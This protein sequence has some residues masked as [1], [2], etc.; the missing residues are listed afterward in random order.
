MEQHLRFLERQVASPDLKWEVLV[1]DNNCK[2]STPEMLRQAAL[3]FPVP[4]RFVREEKQG[5]SHARNR[6]IR[7]SRGKYL[8]FTDD[9]TQPDHAWVESV[10]RTFKERKCDAVAG[11]IALKLAC[12]R[13]VWLTD[14]LLAFLA[15]LDYGPTEKILSV[16]EAPP[17]GANMAFLASVF[18]KVGGFDPALGRTGNKLIGGEEIDLFQ[19]FLKMGLTAIYQPRAIVRHVVDQ[20]RLRKSYFRKLHFNTGKIGGQR[21]LPSGR[22][23]LGIP[24]YIFPQ[25]ARSL[26]NYVGTVYRTGINASLR[27]ELTV[28]YFLGFI[29]GRGQ[30]HLAG[31]KTL[32]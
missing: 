7:E 19:R 12:D 29:L 5:L 26:L 9:D 2:D 32:S 27:K 15:H 14:E 1:V 6:G 25:L 22:Q 23:V 4:F 13:P 8:L 31:G 18:D 17:I 10:C 24:L 28:W 3:R 16:E 21:Y 11:K 30:Q 20:D